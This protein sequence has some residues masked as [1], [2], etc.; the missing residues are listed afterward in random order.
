MKCRKFTK[1][2]NKKI[3]EP[4]GVDAFF[5]ELPCRVIDIRKNGT[6]YLILLFNRKKRWVYSDCVKLR[7]TGYDI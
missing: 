3:K 4:I 1:F 2:Y 7:N 6:K 5:C